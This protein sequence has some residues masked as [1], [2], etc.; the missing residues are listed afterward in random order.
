MDGL[1]ARTADSKQQR[2][3]SNNSQNNYNSLKTTTAISK[4]QQ[5]QTNKSQNY[6]TF[7]NKSKKQQQS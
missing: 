6:N 3:H 5:S 4:Q 7:Q 2:S 1:K